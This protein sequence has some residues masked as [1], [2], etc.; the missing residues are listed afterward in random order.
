MHLKT[1]FRED[2]SP[3]CQNIHDQGAERKEKESF[4]CNVLGRGTKWPGLCFLCLSFSSP[5]L[6]WQIF[7][8]FGT[9]YLGCL[10]FMN[11]VLSPCGV[12]GKTFISTVSFNPHDNPIRSRAEG[13]H[14]AAREARAVVTPMY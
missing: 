12:P 13:L 2:A 6:M 8:L 1:I 7:L 14:V 10:F 4:P 3:N 5:F 11:D 9:Q